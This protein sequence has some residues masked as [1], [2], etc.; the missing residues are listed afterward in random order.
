MAN[1]RYVKC[2]KRSGFCYLGLLLQHLTDRAR[3]LIRAGSAATL[4]VD[5]LQAADD[6]LCIH[7]FNE[8][9]NALC[10]TMAATY[11][12]DVGYFAINDIK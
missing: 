12:L 7:A 1:N 3:E 10:I 2:L 4:A 8:C 11:E 9:S 6:L 5:L